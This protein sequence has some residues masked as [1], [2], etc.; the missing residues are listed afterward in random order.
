MSGIGDKAVIMC[1]LSRHSNN[2]PLWHFNGGPLPPNAV[3]RKEYLE[4]TRVVE[5]NTGFYTC[6]KKLQHKTLSDT[7]Q[8]VVLSECVNSRLYLFHII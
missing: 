4:L 3:I 2:Q 8:L 6:F 5:E 1:S 7:A